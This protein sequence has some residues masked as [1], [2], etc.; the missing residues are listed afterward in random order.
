[1]KLLE[2]TIKNFRAIGSGI[3]DR[4]ITINLKSASD[5]ND[6]VILIGANNAGK[7]SILSAYDYFVNNY[8]AKENDFNDR[9]QKIEII[10]KL[11]AESPNDADLIAIKQFFNSNDEILEVKKIWEYESPKKPKIG[12]C[13]PEKPNNWH[14]GNDT[15]QK[16][17]DSQIR[18]SLPTP[19]W[20]NGF[21]DLETLIKDFQTHIRKIVVEKLQD[22]PEYKALQKAREDFQQLVSN[23]PQ[24]AEIE[25]EIND[26]IKDVFPQVFLSIKNIG[27]DIKFVDNLQKFTQ[28]Y[29]QENQ[30]M[31]DLNYQ[32]HGV[33]RQFAL[34]VSKFLSAL[35]G[36]KG[37]KKK[38]VNE[39]TS[40]NTTNNIRLKTKMLLIEEPELYLHPSAIRSMQRLLYK[41]AETSE[42]QILCAT[43]SP[44]AIDLSKEQSS[45]VRVV[46][47]KGTTQ[48][49][50]VQSSLFNKSDRDWLRMLREFDPYVCEGF[51]A[52]K[53]LLVEGDTEAVVVKELLKKL[54]QNEQE[55]HIVNCRGKATIP[56]FQKIFCH[57]HIP[58]FVFHD[59]DYVY[60]RNKKISTAWLINSQIWQEIENARKSGLTEVH[61]FV[62][63]PEFER[64]HGYIPHSND[65]P[66][67]AYQEVNKW[68]AMWDSEYIQ[69]EKCI[70]KY[71]KQILGMVK[72]EEDFS[73]KWIEQNKYEEAPND[74]LDEP[75]QLSFEEAIFIKD[76]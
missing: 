54:H 64:Q 74:F 3:E 43:H 50:Q 16:K 46:R 53:V 14:F 23:D 75:M 20:I 6:I 31:V 56:L 36:I 44:I 57:F 32:G 22:S 48:C 58:Y 24:T 55:L 27:N 15:Q 71:L 25:K 29:A 61:R 63:I 68:I 11:K 26:I 12:L 18:P 30:E 42:F 66:F 45:L 2:L 62:F 65:K 51:F 28:I 60:D 34:S 40:V 37:I 73:Q 70:I 59:M 19:I 69:K 17:F 49:Y 8:E 7:S 21:T 4:G 5:E 39:I 72:I 52:N 9:N 33:R 76:K 10:V 41:L 1:M 35:D 67:Y 13:Y 38:T 47:E